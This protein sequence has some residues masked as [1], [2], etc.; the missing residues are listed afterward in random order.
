MFPL[1]MPTGGPGIGLFFSSTRGITMMNRAGEATAVGEL[2]Y[3]DLIGS[4]AATVGTSPGAE[5][6]ILANVIDVPAAAA[7][8]AADG[9]LGIFCVATE[10]A[11]D[12]ARVK[13]DIDG[14]VM[15][16]C[17]GNATPTAVSPGSAAVAVAGAQSYLQFDPAINGKEIAVWHQA[18]GTVTNASVLREVW[19]NG[20]AGLFFSQRVT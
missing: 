3:V 16:L 10:V 4:D 1:F 13:V 8:V 17:Q 11:A 7:Q 19:L 5:D 2:L 18:A 20:W 15:A 9:A 6:Y 12:D 14:R